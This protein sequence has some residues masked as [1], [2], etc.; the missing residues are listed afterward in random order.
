MVGK[1][2]ENCGHFILDANLCFHCLSLAFMSQRVNNLIFGKPKALF[3]FS[4]WYS[5]GEGKGIRGEELIK[6]G[7]KWKQR[8][9]S[10]GK[11]IRVEKKKEK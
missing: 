1:W 10:G 3:I 6:D 2:P 8:A 11:G 4:E 5:D 7:K 9:D